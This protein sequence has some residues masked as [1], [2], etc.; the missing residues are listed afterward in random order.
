MEIKNK[1]I[2]VTGAGGFIG[3]HLAETLVRKGA[4]VKALIHY[5]SNNHWGW[6]ED[7]DLRDDMEVISGD[8]RDNFMMEKI[9]KDVDIVFNLAAL[10]AIPYSYQAPESYI[11]TNIKGALN[12]A[13]A[14]LRND[15]SKIIQISTSE[16]Y[17]TAKYV[18]IDEDHPLQPQSPYSASKIGS[19]SIM[20][21][22]FLSFNLPVVIA[23]PFNTY[24][25]RQSAR[26]VIPTI[27]SQLLQSSRIE[28][29]DT[30]T[31]RDFNYVADTCKGL[32]S[33]AESDKTIGEVIN[34]GSNTEI[35]IKELITLIAVELEVEPK[36]V[37]SNERQ[38]PSKSEVKRLV[39]N[40]GKI[41]K[42]TAYSPEITI[43][44]GL[45]LTI[46]W[47]KDNLSKYKS[48]I[49]NI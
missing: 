30:S 9:T 49:Y 20:L 17:G 19:D 22:H 33:L 32:I 27:I 35:S 1:K 42:M 15:I 2:L 28:I 8:V 24:G 43:K 12:I 48:D 3:S 37:V 41:K 26:A 5:N 4:K 34:I 46:K 7:S 39:C 47:F 29:G 23:R 25:P 45:S 44:K 38:R 31:T 18:P 6:L 40:N 14:G 16:V 13:Q 11:E 10:I 21:S 36:I